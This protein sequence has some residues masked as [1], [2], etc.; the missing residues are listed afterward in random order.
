M[1]LTCMYVL[2]VMDHL[3]NSKITNNLYK[4]GD[5]RLVF[6]KKRRRLNLKVKKIVRRRSRGRSTSITLIF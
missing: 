6:T 4:C 5:S 2:M 3:Q 1:I